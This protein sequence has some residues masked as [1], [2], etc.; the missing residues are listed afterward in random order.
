LL[1]PILIA[2]AIASIVFLLLSSSTVWMQSSQSSLV[3]KTMPLG[4]TQ[5]SISAQSIASDN[6]SGKGNSSLLQL[7]N[8]TAK[9][10][11]ETSEFTAPPFVKTFVIYM[12]NEFHEGWPEEAHRLVSNSNGYTIPTR[13]VISNGTTIA[14]HMADAPWAGPH[15]YVVKVVN[16]ETDEVVWQTPLMDYPTLDRGPSNSGTTVL[17]VGEYRIDA[18]LAFEGGEQQVKAKTK[19]LGITV[20]DTPV[21]PL[22][23]L[24]LGFFYTP[25]EPVANPYDDDDGLHYGNLEYYEKQFP[26]NGLKIESVHR[27]HFASCSFYDRGETESCIDEGGKSGELY[28][29]DNKSADHALILWSSTKSYDEIASALDKLTWA[30]VYI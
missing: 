9:I 27:F 23:N 24:T 2:F 18:Y 15:D 22:S 20:I 25:Q 26:A 4:N 5:Q 19:S 30:N 3:P 29:K 8:S 1:T 16:N 14:F 13:L 11:H 6:S 17:P 10:V 28:W 21:D 7:L 12:A